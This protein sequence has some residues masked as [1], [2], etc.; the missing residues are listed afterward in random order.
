MTC[1]IECGPSRREVRDQW[2]GIRCPMSWLECLRISSPKHLSPLT[3]RPERQAPETKAQSLS[4]SSAITVT[5][6][7][8]PADFPYD[9][10][11]YPWRLEDQRIQREQSTQ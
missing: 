1:S 9:N 5:A 11:P 2:V 8:Y 3:K 7:H 10:R 4:L 6:L